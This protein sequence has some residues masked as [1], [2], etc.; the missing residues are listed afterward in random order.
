MAPV[1]SGDFNTN[2]TRDADDLDILAA[3]IRDEVSDRHLDVNED[4]QVNLDDQRHWVR[5]ANY[6]NTYLGD[7]NLDSEFNSSDLID[8][9]ASGTYELD[10]EAGWASGD[11]DGS[12]H[13][14]SSDLIVALADGGYEMGTRAAVSGVPEPESAILL[15][16]AMTVVF[17]L[18]QSQ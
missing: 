13:F 4:G 18:R 8:V 10:I 2:D 14:N 1:L 9:L 17:R 15:L 12:G 3:A 7:A 11:F 6:A 16:I 5:D